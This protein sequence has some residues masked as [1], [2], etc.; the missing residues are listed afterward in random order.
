MPEEVNLRGVTFRVTIPEKG[1]VLFAATDKVGQIKFERATFIWF[2]NT[3]GLVSANALTEAYKWI[4]A[5]F[6]GS[7]EHKSDPIGNE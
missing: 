7:F 2:V 5:V 1:V 3:Y 6:G 4:E